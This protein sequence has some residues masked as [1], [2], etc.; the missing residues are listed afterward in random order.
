MVD[1]KWNSSNMDITFKVVTHTLDESELGHMYWFVPIDGDMPISA[2]ANW[3]GFTPLGSIARKFNWNTSLLKKAVEECN[4]KNQIAIINQVSPKLFLV[5]K[6]RGK[7]AANFLINDLL[8]AFE[9]TGTKVA[10]FTHYGFVQNKLPKD[11]VRTILIEMI[12]RENKKSLIDKIII[13]IDA[14][15]HEEFKSIYINLMNIE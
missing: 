11:E 10:N 3:D 14:R 12:K 13:D 6:T 15:V 7:G 1:R 2:T 5:P 9:E 8:D 4:D